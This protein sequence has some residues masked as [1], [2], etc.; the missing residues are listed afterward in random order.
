ML[1][2]V[3]I[4]HKSLAKQIDEIAPHPGINITDDKIFEMLAG[5]KPASIGQYYQVPWKQT[6]EPPRRTRTL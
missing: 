3:S 1:N 2:A 4:L 6:E 5:D